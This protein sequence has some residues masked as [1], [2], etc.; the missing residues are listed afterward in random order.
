MIQ[1]DNGMTRRASEI[2]S[3]IT[4]ARR[5]G[6]MIATA[7]V[8]AVPNDAIAVRHNAVSRVAVAAATNAAAV[9]AATIDAVAA[10]AAAATATAIATIDA[11]AA[12]AAA[13]A[14]RAAA[15]AA[16]AANRPRTIRRRRSASPRG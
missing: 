9:A 11:A 10:A 8:V 4:G 6:T 15:A 16:K 2:M 12:A 5:A 1:G 3:R 7:A 13:K 14:H